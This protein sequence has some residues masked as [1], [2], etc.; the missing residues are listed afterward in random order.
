MGAV[1]CTFLPESPLLER[2]TTAGLSYASFGAFPRWWRLRFVEI[3]LWCYD[4]G[5]I[6]WGQRY[7]SK[8]G[9]QQAVWFGKI[10]DLYLMS[11]LIHELADGQ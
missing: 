8:D 2:N 6:L 5:L 10:P 3:D 11:L 4:K 1:L 9:G 7:D